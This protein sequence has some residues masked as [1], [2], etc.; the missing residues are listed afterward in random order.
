MNLDAPRRALMEALARN[1]REALRRVLG[2]LLT[3]DSALGR[4]ERARLLAEVAQ[5]GAAGQR[6]REFFA[7]EEPALGRR[8]L[9]SLGDDAPRELRERL[10]EL[11]T[12]GRDRPLLPVWPRNA[13]PQPRPTATPRPGDPLPRPP[14]ATP[15]PDG[16]L[17]RPPVATPRPD[18][19][20]PRILP[21]PA[22]TP[23]GTR[24]RPVLKPTPAPTP[25][26][27]PA[28]RLRPDATPSPWPVFESP[29]R[30]PLPPILGTPARKPEPAA[31]PTPSPST[32]SR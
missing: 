4:A 8:L 25:T 21:T 7:Q 13:D 19:Q 18:G 6:L 31:A 24:D 12:P 30:L 3:D 11:L 14:V 27:T 28:P 9:E 1:D 22:K 5:E 2:F 15:R 10:R 17:P 29:P 32:D 26:P 20:L 16:Q 23:E